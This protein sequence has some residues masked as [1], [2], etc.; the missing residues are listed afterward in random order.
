MKSKKENQKKKCQKMKMKKTTFKILK[1]YIFHFV[2]SP[3]CMLKTPSKV[4]LDI[5]KETARIF[6]Y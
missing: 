3:S 2:V 6:F 5:S 4:Q 1:M